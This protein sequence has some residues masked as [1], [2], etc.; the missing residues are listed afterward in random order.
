MPLENKNRH[1]KVQDNV[2]ISVGQSTACR[3]AI[4]R[5]HTSEHC[6]RLRVRNRLSREFQGKYRVVNKA[7]VVVQVRKDTAV[8]VR[9]RKKEVAKVRHFSRIIANFRVIRYERL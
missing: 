5:R 7:A 4:Y 6:Y 8:G 2:Q 1:R 9:S 3:T